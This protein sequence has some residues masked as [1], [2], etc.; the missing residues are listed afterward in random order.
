[1]AACHSDSPFQIAGDNLI[2]CHLTDRLRIAFGAADAVVP[3]TDVTP[4]LAVIVPSCPLR[5][6]VRPPP[7]LDAETNA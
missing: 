6:I 2:G 5:P 4:A 7:H 3:I 1:M